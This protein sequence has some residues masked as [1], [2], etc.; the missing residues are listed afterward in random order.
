MDA[1]L[2]A[3]DSVRERMTP[4]IEIATM[5]GQAVEI[6]PRSPLS[7]M[8]DVLQHSAGVDDVF[9]LDFHPHISRPIVMRILQDCLIHGLAFVPVI[10]PERAAQARAI[11][12]AVGRDRGVALRIA[13]SPFTPTGMGIDDLI[14]EL[15]EQTEVAQA[16]ADLFL[17]LGRLQGI[18]TAQ[19]VATVLAE[20]SDI[21]SWRNLVVSGTTMPAGFGQDQFGLDADTVLPRRE[22]QL[23]Q[24]LKRVELK[25]EPTFSDYGIQGTGRPNKGFRPI[26]NLR[27]TADDHTVVARGNRKTSNAVQHAELCARMTRRPEFKGAAFSRGDAWIAQ[28]ATGALQL[29][30]QELMRAI[31]TSH[32]FQVITS[33]LADR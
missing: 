33:A 7:R 17:D 11:V 27:Y 3:P 15:L 29:R 14:Q 6:S 26:P 23:F 19:D 10:R 5:K 8:G 13:I 12:A 24:D 28:C 31:G 4:L 1:L 20:I 22:W 16:D 2:N 32:H 9:F 18:L 30:D 25:R 21:G